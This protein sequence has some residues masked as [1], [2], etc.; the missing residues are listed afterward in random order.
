MQE[1]RME[2]F[3]YFLKDSVRLTVD[4][5]QTDQSRGASP[6]PIEKPFDPNAMRIDL[7]K[8]EQ[9]KEIQP[10]D[11]LTAIERRES[12]RKFRHEP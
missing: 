7:V 10:I 6:P 8:A 3:R 4:F 12:R 5:S 11:L 9:W 1:S 2:K